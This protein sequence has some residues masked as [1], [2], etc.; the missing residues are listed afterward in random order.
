MK[1][2][3]S[4]KAMAL[5]KTRGLEPAR[6]APYTEGF[7]GI[8]VEADQ[9]V[10]TTRTGRNLAV[11]APDGLVAE[12]L[13]KQ[14]RACDLFEDCGIVW[15]ESEPFAAQVT[16]RVESYTPK[17]HMM[18]W[19]DFSHEEPKCFFLVERDP[20][21]IIGNQMRPAG[22]TGYVI[23]IRLAGSVS[24]WKD[25]RVLLHRLAEK[26]IEKTDSSLLSPGIRFSFA[27]DNLFTKW[28]QRPQGL[29][30][31]GTLAGDFERP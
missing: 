7:G 16:A 30:F 24:K 31:W 13:W 17:L 15:Y 27:V 2:D 14:Y 26:L 9:V 28:S 22:Q 6:L 8:R 21:A 23:D 29:R 12:T 4:E 19:L 20:F 11:N 18:G 10:L 5:I 3:Y 25:D 1:G